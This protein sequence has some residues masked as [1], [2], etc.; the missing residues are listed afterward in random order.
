MASASIPVVFGKTYVDGDL[1]WDGGIPAVG[2]N[3]PVKP[4]YDDGIRNLIVVHLGREEPVDRD[5]FPGCHIIEIMPQENLGGPISGTMNF[6]S[7]AAKMNMKRGYNDTVRILEPLYKTGRALSKIERAFQTISEE[8]KRFAIQ[9]SR[10]K[11]EIA[12]SGENI[13]AILRELKGEDN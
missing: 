5:K 10:I 2:D 11:E 6:S 12:R 7:E 4:L 3:V 9:N 13:D 8:Q 1:Y